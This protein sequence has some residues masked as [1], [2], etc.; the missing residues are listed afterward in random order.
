MMGYFDPGS[1][2][3]I[4]QLLIAAILVG[5]PVLFIGLLFFIYRV[6]KR[7]ASRKSEEEPIITD[8][9]E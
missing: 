8:E 6:R 1:G 4:L 3:F 2:S 5:C 9:V 7:D